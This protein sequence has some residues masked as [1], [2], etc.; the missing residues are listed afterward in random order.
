MMT[1]LIYIKLCD[2]PER[3]PSFLQAYELWFKQILY[4]IDSIRECFQAKH[5]VEEGGMLEVRG[6]GLN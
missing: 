1:T 2:K 4:E 6:A 5:G 3:D